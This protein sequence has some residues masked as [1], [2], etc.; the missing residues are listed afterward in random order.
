M[1]NRLESLKVENGRLVKEVSDVKSRAGNGGGSD[2]FASLRAEIKD[3]RSQLE[4][5]VSAQAKLRTFAQSLKAQTD[6]NVAKE[7]SELKK[8]K[9]EVADV[10]RQLKEARDDARR[11]VLNMKELKRTLGGL[12]VGNMKVKEIKGLLPASAEVE[13]LDLRSLESV[14]PEEID[15]ERTRFMSP[16]PPTS[17]VK[18][19]LRYEEGRNRGG[20][21]ARNIAAT[22]S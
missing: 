19:Q 17:E 22:L 6:R 9:D 20:R 14:L 7:R 10:R 21:K 4:A 2:T 12:A 13:T 1:S 5:S 8:S 15:V 3:L 16:R 11:N 18:Q